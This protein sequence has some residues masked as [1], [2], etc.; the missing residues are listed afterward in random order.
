MAGEQTL[1]ALRIRRMA[2]C[3][4]CEQPA[5]FTNQARSLTYLFMLFFMSCAALLSS[6]SICDGPSLKFRLRRG[7]K[8]ASSA[9]RSRQASRAGVNLHADLNCESAFLGIRSRKG[10]RTVNPQGGIDA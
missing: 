5:H 7:F 1:Y 2:C 9:I 3:R 4:S 6:G 8:P 10:G